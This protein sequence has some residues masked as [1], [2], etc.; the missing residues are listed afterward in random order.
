M[1]FHINLCPIR[2]LIAT[3]N[4]MASLNLKFSGYISVSGSGEQ[5]R[6]FEEAVTIMN[7]AFPGKCE[8]FKIY[9]GQA[10]SGNSGYQY[11]GMV[12]CI[13]I[14]FDRNFA[15]IEYVERMDY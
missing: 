6:I 12:R 8:K 11:R 7:K 15:V 5:T 9:G 3:L 1:D 2:D 4:S 13:E 10:S 14:K